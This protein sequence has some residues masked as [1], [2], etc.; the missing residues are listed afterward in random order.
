MNQ[1][2]PVSLRDLLT[3]IIVQFQLKTIT[4]TKKRVHEA[5][6]KSE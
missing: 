1:V 3:A 2:A 4:I 5:G 6:R